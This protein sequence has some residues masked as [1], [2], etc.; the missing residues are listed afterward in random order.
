MK[1]NEIKPLFMDFLYNEIT[2]EDQR[3][4]EA[5][6]SQCESC[7][8]ELESLQKTSNIL[9]QWEDVD[10]DFNV[11]MVSENVSWVS[12][13]KQ[14]LNQFFPVPKKLAYGFAY[15][16]AGIFLLLAIANTE[17]SYR[18]GEF[19]MSM[20][21][22]SKPASQQ[23]PENVLTQEFLNQWRED[24]YYLMSS[25]IQ[26]SEQRQRKE[27][28]SNILQLRQEFARQR[29]EDLNLVG[30]GL[31]NIEQTTVRQLKRTDSNLNE[32]IQ[33]IN[34]QMK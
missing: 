23:Q 11:V 30:L 25:L 29:I 26:Q 31:D 6:L 7:Q 33:L 12:L 17:I 20:G 22:F 21:L 2:K 14:R 28:T 13:V 15:A 8:K 4:F 5:H 18:Q 32:L 9:Q 10:P 34:T 1:C 27:R 19:K 16:A 3:L 24:N